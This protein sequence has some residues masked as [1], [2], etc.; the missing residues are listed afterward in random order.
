[1]LGPCHRMKK[2]KKLFLRKKRGSTDVKYLM[3]TVRAFISRRVLYLCWLKL[4]CKVDF[5]KH[6]QC[7]DS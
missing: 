4:M 2:A 6:F 7:C 5:T 1:M 3:V